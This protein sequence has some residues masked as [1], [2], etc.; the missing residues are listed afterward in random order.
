M[1]KSKVASNVKVFFVRFW[2]SIAIAIV[3]VLIIA[4]IKAFK[5]TPFK[6]TIRNSLEKVRLSKILAEKQAE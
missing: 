6:K 5:S 4:I 2:Y 1:A 3:I